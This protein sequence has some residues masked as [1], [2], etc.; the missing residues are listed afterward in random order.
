MQEGLQGLVLSILGSSR[1]RTS[2][3]SLGLMP[4]IASMVIVQVFQHL[5]KDRKEKRSQARANWVMVFLATGIALLQAWT[6]AG[7]LQYREVAGCSQRLLQLLTAAMLL[8]GSFVIKWLSDRNTEWGIGGQGLLIVINTLG[9]LA[10]MVVAYLTTAFVAGSIRSVVLKLLS[11]GCVCLTIIVV[12]LMMEGTEFRNVAR[13]VM[14]NNQY[15]EQDYVA[16]R[17]NPVGTMPVMYVMSIFT[18][19]YYVLQLAD[20]LMPGREW[21]QKGL[22]LVNLNSVPG[23]VIFGIILWLLTMVLAAIFVQP[24]EIAE[25]L[26]R[27]GSYLDGIEPGEATMRQLR[28]QTLIASVISATAASIMVLPLLY[29]HARWGSYSSFYTM[30]MTVMILAGMVMSILEELKVYG[31]MEQYRMLL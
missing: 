2:V 19:P 11:G 18:V 24:Q 27:Q 15:A 5:M 10:K 21:V 29:I 23:V 8:T 30:P 26:Q 3:F 25:D 13:R 1:D 7:E 22:Q 9:S 31:T 16:I 28:H 6:N 20:R 14:I 4:W 12:M 17:L